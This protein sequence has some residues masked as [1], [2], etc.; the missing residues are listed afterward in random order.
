MRGH[1]M[2]CLLATL[3]STVVDHADR[4]AASSAECRNAGHGAGGRYRPTCGQFVT[5]DEP[6]VALTNV[7]MIDGTG[8]RSRRPDQTIVIRDGRIAEVGPSARV[9]VPAGARGWIS[10]A[11]R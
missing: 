11:T 2:A 10:P 8:A 3:A 6:V 1:T 4:G 5:V 7:T 9:T